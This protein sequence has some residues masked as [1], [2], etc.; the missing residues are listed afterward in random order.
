MIALKSK[1]T[2]T[3]VAIRQKHDY[4]SSEARIATVHRNAAVHWYRSTV[5][6]DEEFRIKWMEM[7]VAKSLHNTDSI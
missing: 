1:K 5:P 2:T 6:M 7:H 4:A 3:V